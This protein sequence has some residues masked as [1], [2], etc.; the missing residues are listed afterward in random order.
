MTTGQL[1]AISFA[2][3]RIMMR[4]RIRRAERK[5]HDLNHFLD[6]YRGLGDKNTAP[7]VDECIRLKN[8]IRHMRAGL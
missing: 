1:Q 8:K 6:Y 3:S 5:L 4:F 7:L 2:F